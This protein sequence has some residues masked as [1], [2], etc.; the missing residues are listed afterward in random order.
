MWFPVRY[1]PSAFAVSFSID[2]VLAERAGLVEQR[3]AG[4]LLVHLPNHH[5]TQPFS[6]P[7]I[8]ILFFLTWILG[9]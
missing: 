3:A 9:H 8:L 2:P 6:L 7:P 5:P 1:T 4:M